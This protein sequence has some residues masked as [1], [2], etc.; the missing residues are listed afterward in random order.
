MDFLFIV[1]TIVGIRNCSMFCCTLL[2]V[3]SSFAITLMGK[4]KLFVLCCFLVAV[5]L[6]LTV[7]WFCLLFVVVVFP[8]HTHYF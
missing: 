8:D 6:F 5:W 4:R 3:N 7:P 1:T 2:Y